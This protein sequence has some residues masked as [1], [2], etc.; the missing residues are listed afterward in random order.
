[1]TPGPWHARAEEL[2]DWALARLFVRTDRFGGYYRDRESGETRTVTRPTKVSPEEFSREVLL[3]HCR[4]S[5]TD[6]VIGAL[7][8][9]PGKDGTG[10]WAANDIDNH[11]H[12]DERAERNK[13]YAEHQ[14]RKLAGL[15]LRPLVPTW[16]GGSFHALVLFNTS[17]PGPILFSF[18]QWMAS[19][20]ATFGDLKIDTFPKQP[21]VDNC[22]NWLRVVGRHHSRNVFPSVFDGS[23]WIEGAA[24]VEY[25]LALAGDSP[26]LIPHAARPRVEEGQKKDPW[27]MRVTGDEPDVL[28]EFSQSVSLDDVVRWHER[29][30][31]HAVTSRKRS[32]DGSERVEF[33][34][35]GKEGKQLSFSVETVKGM[36][37]TYNFSSNAG[38]P[39]GAGLTP[40]HV[41]S[42]YDFNS[43]DKRSLAKL[44]DKMRAERGLPNSSSRRDAQSEAA[45]KGAEAEKN[46]HASLIIT[47]LSR[48]KAKPVRYLVP[49]RIPAGKLI[50]AAGRGGSGKST[51]SRAL[52]A[53]ISAGRC[54]FGMSYHNPI[55]GKVLIVAAEDGPEDTI[56]PG[57]LACGAD[58]DRIEILEGVKYE[59]KKSDFTLLPA[60]VDLVKARLKQSPDTRIIIIDP[61]ASFVG[62]T[63]VDDHRAT[64]LR[65]VLDPLSA[66]AEEYGVCVL[67]IA[68]MNKAT[69]EAVDRIA[70]SAAYRDAVRAAYLATE[71]P[72][73][74][75]RRLMIP[76]KENLPGFD[77]TA[78]P[79]R[80]EKLTDPEA[81]VVFLSK[82]FSDL[83][84]ADRDIIREQMRRVV[85]DAPVT[86]DANE[87]TKAKKDD[88]NKVAKCA[89][90]LQEF[91]REHAYPSGE[92]VAAAKEMEFTF[93]NV[94]K[95]KKLLKDT[96]GLRN[97]NMGRLQGVWW[98]GFG[99]PNDWK[100]RPDPSPTT[101]PES[102]ES[103]E[104]PNSPK[105]PD[106]G[107]TRDSQS[108]ETQETEE[109]FETEES[110]VLFVGSRCEI[111][112]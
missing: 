94:S 109:T 77:R 2:A 60:H 37:I 99:H 51:W 97:S 74:E 28:R 8:L 69:G 96:A 43:C 44:A 112:D 81:M 21:E 84:T 64:E 33:T 9:T 40:A 10:L 20:A 36:P 71:D 12:S 23:A 104:S 100:L 30:G 87:A 41:R 38:M 55:R 78:L 73:D 39:A 93:D 4:A 75:S 54:A 58:V 68:H 86:V 82:Q 65:L 76:V 108:N 107:N 61:I 66:M 17:V 16:G 25:V 15:G 52:A 103:H 13:R 72:G 6:D 67:L 90:F 53:D 49:G 101:A 102:H 7:P 27:K 46:G 62:R 89:E 29:E 111:P 88:K 42:Y 79:F 92:I 22:G 19:D 98:S 26:G 80:L 45:D 59:G 95:A 47:A 18:G 5:R 91:L 63:R 85:F 106:I 35:N 3:K 110:G 34:R 11:D 48:L 57:L 32:P 105:S 50:L 24:A 1:M 14:F 31:G 70:G 83:E 56:L